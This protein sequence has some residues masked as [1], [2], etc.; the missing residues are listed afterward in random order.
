MLAG[1]SFG[2]QNRGTNRQTDKRTKSKVYEKNA[3]GV[4]SSSSSSLASVPVFSRPK[5]V[6]CRISQQVD[7]VVRRDKAH[8]HSTSNEDSKTAENASRARTFDI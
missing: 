6:F 2:E 7:V 1:R 5:L 3:Q 4:K 8:S